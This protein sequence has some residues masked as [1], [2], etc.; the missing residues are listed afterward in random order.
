MSSMKSKANN[1]PYVRPANLLHVFGIKDEQIAV[2]FDTI[3]DNGEQDACVFLLRIR[4]GNKNWFASC[5]AKYAPLDAGSGFH[6]ILD[7][8][9]EKSTLSGVSHTINEA[10][11][12]G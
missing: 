11:P 9:V 3:Q 2:S 10:M 1:T 12:L 5:L 7:E 6:V 8:S 4:I